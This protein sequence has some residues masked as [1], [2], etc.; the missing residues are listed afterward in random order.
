MTVSQLEIIQAHANQQKFGV[1][2]F[3]LVSLDA[4]C[5]YLG[6]PKRQVNDPTAQALV[7]W[8]S[9]SPAKSQWQ[10]ERDVGL[11]GAWTCRSAQVH[12]PKPPTH[13]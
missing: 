3:D 12:A 1:W 10:P 11:I 9:G 5:I 4:L 6:A 7:S 2:T 13:S 8:Q